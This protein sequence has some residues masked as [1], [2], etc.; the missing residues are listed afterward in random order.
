[1]QRNIQAFALL[2]LGD[3]KTDGLIDYRQ[4]DETRRKSIND[5]DS[6]FIDA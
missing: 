5:G 3:A 1:V 4:N 2:L 6:L